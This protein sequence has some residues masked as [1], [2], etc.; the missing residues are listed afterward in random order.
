MTMNT[1][2]N[3]P[4][5]YTSGSCRIPIDSNM[6]TTLEGIVGHVIFS[7]VQYDLVGDIMKIEMEVL[8]VTA[9]KLVSQMLI[10]TDPT[11]VMAEETDRAEPWA[12]HY[13]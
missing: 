9:I 11:V 5:A 1:T 6:N 2:Y 12:T 3:E 4:R 13:V 7:K 10:S 8:A